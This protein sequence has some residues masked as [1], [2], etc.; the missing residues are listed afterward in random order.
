M[1]ITLK[2][3]FT[4]TV[5]SLRERLS[6]ITTSETRYSNFATRKITVSRQL[7]YGHFGILTFGL[8]ECLWGSS[9]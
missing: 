2:N 6:I 8:L 5:Y 3:P 4:I 9:T 1:T 7:V